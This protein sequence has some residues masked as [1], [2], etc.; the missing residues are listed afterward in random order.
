MK[1]EEIIAAE[2]NGCEACANIC[3][4][5]AIKMIR[6]A[7]GFAYPEINRELCDDCGKCDAICPAL[8]FTKTFPEK[9]PKTFLAINPDENIRRQSSSGGVFSALSEI[10]LRGGGLVF[11]AAFDKK[12]HVVHTCARTLDELEN[13]RGNKYVQSQIGDVYRQIKDALE[14]TEVLFVGTPCQCA[15]LKNFLGSKPENRLTVDIIC[16]GVPSPSWWDN[17]IGTVG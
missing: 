8:N 3:P 7:E 6:D 14:S 2:C 17:Y 4:R 9:I 13:L 5:N 1:I 11:G 16:H 12:F 15:A 10:I